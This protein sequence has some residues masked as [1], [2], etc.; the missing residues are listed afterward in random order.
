MKIFVH[1]I[2]YIKCTTFAYNIWILAY[3]LHHFYIKI[4][5]SRH[6]I[7][8]AAIMY[9]LR[10]NDNKKALVMVQNRRQEM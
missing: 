8:I 7:E 2:L 1:L 9:F 3:I 10:N 6:V 5:D 4:Q